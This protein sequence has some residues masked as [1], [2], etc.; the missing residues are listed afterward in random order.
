[1][2]Q[3]LGHE[4]QLPQKSALKSVEED[5]RNVVVGEASDGQKALACISSFHPDLAI[6]DIDIPKLDGFGV[7]KELNTLKLS[8]KIIFLTLHND[9]KVF[10]SAMQLGAKGYLLKESALQETAAAI[11]VVVSERTYVSSAIA[12]HLMEKRRVAHASDSLLGDL[13][14]TERKILKMITTGKSSK[15]I[16]RQAFDSLRDRRESSGQCLSE[17]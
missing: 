9:E 17:A 12:V 15:E 5:C 2:R 13:T 11:E 10:N 16:R 3:R 14:P 7:V 6:L 1:M 4:K 8:T